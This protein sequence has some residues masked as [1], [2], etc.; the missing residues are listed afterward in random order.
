M[1]RL[2]DKDIELG[3]HIRW[4]L[5]HGG[6]VTNPDYEMMSLFIEESAVFLRL[7]TP[8]LRVDFFFLVVR[9]IVRLV[10]FDL[11]ATRDV[12]HRLCLRPRPVILVPDFERCSARVLR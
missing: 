8:R 5:S 11:P 1:F 6:A 12:D 2:A 10:F 4:F 7:V 9:L 3:T